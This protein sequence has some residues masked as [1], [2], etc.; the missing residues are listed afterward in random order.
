MEF[1]FPREQPP[2][3]WAAAMEGHPLSSATSPL[4]IIPSEIL[5]MIA[6]YVAR[7]ESDLASLALVNSSCRQLARTFQFRSVGLD[8]NEPS[9]GTLGLLQKEARHKHRITASPSMGICIRKLFVAGTYWKYVDTIVPSP[10]SKN[11]AVD[12]NE[13]SDDSEKGT[14]TERR[15]RLATI[16]DNDVKYLYWPAVYLVIPRLSSLRSLTIKNVTLNDEFL[17]CLVGLPLEDLT[18]RGNFIHPL[19]TNPSVRDICPQLKAI[20][21]GVH[22]KSQFVLH[23]SGPFDS[24]PFFQALFGS[25]A[26]KLQN[27]CIQQNIIGKQEDKYSPIHFNNLSF[28]EL[29]SLTILNP[30]RILAASALWS[31]LRQGLTF[32]D[33]RYDKPSFVHPISGHSRIDTLQTLILHANYR[34]KRDETTLLRFIESNKQIK[35]LVM[36]YHYRDS[37]IVRALDSIRHHNNLQKL[38]I[39]WFERNI[40]EDSL[41]ALS[42]L[43]QVEVL[44]IGAGMGRRHCYDWLVDHESII[45]YIRC[46]RRLRRLIIVRDTY[47]R[48]AND[49]S[50]VVP[51]RYYDHRTLGSRL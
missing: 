21:V 23:R 15:N 3:G 49:P 37:F 16:L 33:I 51:M 38:Y 43:C 32:F 27:I 22:W 40:S 29:K 50:W 13:D 35:T 46:L 9:L 7:E 17:D 19:A 41:G 36:T 8:Y 25:C 24:S 28:P 1:F 11:N 4:F 14:P 34:P 31:I 10:S 20:D 2:L 47:Q 44:R 30:G 5:E 18:I 45:P 12:R 42:Q 48:M 26:A 6:A 39:Q